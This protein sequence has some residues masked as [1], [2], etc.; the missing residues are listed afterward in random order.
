LN[1][2]NYHC[3]ASLTLGIVSAMI[4]GEENLSTR[5]LR[6]TNERGI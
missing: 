1:R 6:T 3:R 2:V 5:Q 4:I